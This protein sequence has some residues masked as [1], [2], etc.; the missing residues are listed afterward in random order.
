MKKTGWLILLPALLTLGTWAQDAPAAGANV[1]E[2]ENAYT[3]PVERLKAPTYADEYCAGFISKE[4][5]PNAH[6]VTGGMNSP[7][8]VKFVL[9]DPVY[10]AGTGYATG[11]QFAVI[12]EIRNANEDEAFAGQRKMVS[13]TGHPYAELG[14]IRVLDTRN[15]QAVAQVE[16]SCEPISPGDTLVP[17]AERTHLTLRDAGR[18][19][20]FAPPNG[21][22]TGRII[23]GRDFDTFLGSGNKA[24]LNVGSN[25]GVKVGDYF[26]AVR[27]YWMDRD[28]EVDSISL[29]ARVNEDTQ[30]HPPSI[31]PALFSK[32][33]SGP[34]IHLKDYP[35]RAVGELLILNVTPTSSTA[36]VIF[37][38]EDVH[39]GD[40]AELE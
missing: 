21:K 11:Q 31:E 26:R 20:R 5:L 18:L 19:D 6:Y 2:T 35:R 10:L 24:Y 25:Q 27:P 12:R 40:F 14:R 17:F 7:N 30:R 15:H 38:L 32:E 9:N 37:A 4:V 36:M 3:F 33:G 39:L 1:I 29:E 28:D 13:A 16:Y 22:T 34:T 23:L 8:S